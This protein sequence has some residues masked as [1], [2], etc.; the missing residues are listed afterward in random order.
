MLQC[1]PARNRIST[2]V[3]CPGTR[4]LPEPKQTAHPACIL[5]V[6]AS[7]AAGSCYCVRWRLR[8]GAAQMALADGWTLDNSPP[9]KPIPKWREPEAKAKAIGMRSSG[10][11]ISSLLPIR[12]VSPSSLSLPSIRSSPRI[13]HKTC[14][15]QKHFYYF[16]IQYVSRA[17]HVF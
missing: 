2:M 11:T 7:V 4:P 5:P 10:K 9:R 8:G 1:Q 15:R 13:H 14:A 16:S 17:Q 6:P 12:N 3:S